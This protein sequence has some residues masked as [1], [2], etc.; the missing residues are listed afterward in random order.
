MP[1]SNYQRAMVEEFNGVDYDPITKEK[2]S[3]SRKY[4]YLAIGSTLA[5]SLYSVLILDPVGKCYRLEDSSNSLGLTFS[6]TLQMVQD[7]FELRSQDQLECYGK[8]LKIWDVFFAVIYTSMYSFWIM[9]LFQR[10]RIILVVPLLAMVADWAENV[11]EILLINSY[12]ESNT[13]SE[14]LV[15][16]GSGINI[17]KWILLTL[18]Y[19]IILIG[20][21]NNIKSALSKAESNED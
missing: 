5:F 18:T 19:V 3:E 1:S 17:F 7:F 2:P 15:S 10:R 4:L 20:I 16:L 11:V 9:Y 13:I 21:F 14:T 6:Y 8:F 12:L